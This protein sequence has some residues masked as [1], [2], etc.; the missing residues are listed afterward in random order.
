MSQGLVTLSPGSLFAGDFRVVRPLA[1][2]GM[3]AVYVVEQTSTGKHRALK[4][5]HPQ[6]LQ[7]ERLRARFVQEAKIGSRIESDHVVEVVGAGIDAEG[8]G[9]TL[10]DTREISS[11]Q[12]TAA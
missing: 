6:M 3:G 5:M 1:G 12:A 11:V 10:E 9:C 7:D 2:G 4:V 8:A